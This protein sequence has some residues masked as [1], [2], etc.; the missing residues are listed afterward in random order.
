MTVPGEPGANRPR[1]QSTSFRA[2]SA[3][4][5]ESSPSPTG[6]GAGWRRDSSAGATE[7]HVQTW[8]I[9]TGML[10]L[11]SVSAL[12][13]TAAG[14]APPAKPAPASGLSPAAGAAPHA[15]AGL[16]PFTPDGPGRIVE[17]RGIRMY[18]EEHGHGPAL[19][20]LH[21]GA[22]NGRQFARQIPAFQD[23]YRLVIPDACGQG[24][25]TDRPGP[26]TYHDMAEDVIAL[27][28]RL[29]IPAARVVGWS[30]GGVIGLDLAIHHPDRIS[31]LVT[32]GANFSPDGVNAGARAW[33]DTATAAAFG[34]DTEKGY[35]RLSPEPDHYRDVMTK[36]IALWHTQPNF[37]AA[38][39]DRIR[40]RTMIVAGEHD[41]I[42]REHTEALARAIPGAK[43]WIVPRASHGVMIER[44]DEVNPVVL[45]FLGR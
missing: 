40:A 12:A 31:H 10:V 37:T 11:L 36:I 4:A 9:R 21:G 6:P 45:D 14:A 41:L 3:A 34:T 16:H 1:G 15:H 32:F 35:R 7:D 33:A 19:L 39:L 27:M 25:T 26:L 18:V 22:G 8:Q 42:R 17:L 23:H 5:G 2:S 44:A 29:Q 38:E 13:A 28:D 30:D 20:L 24:R 43:L